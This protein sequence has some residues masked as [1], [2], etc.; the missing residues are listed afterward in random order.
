MVDKFLKTVDKIEDTISKKKDQL[1]GYIPEI[2]IDKIEEQLEDIG[3]N[4]PRVEIS[5]TI[6]PRIGF[7]INLEN[8]II[9]QNKK[10]K[11]LSEEA[12]DQDE[13]NI[14]R[15]VLI[16]IVQGLDTAI[17][18]KKKLKFRNKELSRILVEG[19]MIPTVKLIY[20][21]P[22]EQELENKIDKEI[23]K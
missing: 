5:L 19:S 7:E 3:Y 9:D 11:I 21:D 18:L 1:L 12:L 2:D 20:L 16:K 23:K 14:S 17:K 4:I 10:E 15:R 8:S 6:P 13:D 22:K